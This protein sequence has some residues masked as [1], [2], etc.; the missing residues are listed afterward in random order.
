MSKLVQAFLSGVFFTYILDFFIF[1]GIKKRYIDV[2]EIDVY[3]NILFADHQNIFIYLFFTLFIGF[4][5]IYVNSTKIKLIIMGTL[6]TLAGLTLLPSLGHSLGE[7][8]LMSKNV[9]L[10]NDRH[11]FVGD[12][13]YSGRKQITFY[14]RELDKIILIDKKELK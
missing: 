1:L 13:Y 11:T 2:Y 3:Y 8:I 10:K 14:D 6:F 5:V 9:T 12:I 4:I 7:M